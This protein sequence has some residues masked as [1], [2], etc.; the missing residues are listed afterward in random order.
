VDRFTGLPQ[1]SLFEIH[2]S[3]VPRSAPDLA[4]RGR[5]GD[6]IL[7]PQSPIFFSAPAPPYN[8]PLTIRRTE[9][10]LSGHSKTQIAKAI[11][12]ADFE[13]RLSERR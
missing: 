12:A 6:Q 13:R 8:V 2:N 4:A 9:L 5:T 7:A 11:Q 10:I 1:Q 3:R